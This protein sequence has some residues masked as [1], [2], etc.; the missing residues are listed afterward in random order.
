MWHTGDVYWFF[1]YPGA[2]VSNFWISG[3]PAS[4]FGY[5]AS[6][7]QLSNFSIVS[8][9]QATGCYRIYMPFS[10]LYRLFSYFPVLLYVFILMTNWMM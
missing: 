3:E 7:L 9:W 2:Y 6:L 5:Q 8:L 10:Y 1:G 4:T